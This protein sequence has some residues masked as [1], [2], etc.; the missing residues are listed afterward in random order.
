M[1]TLRLRS[2]L[3]SIANYIH[4]LWQVE[5]MWHTLDP[6]LHP[7]LPMLHQEHMRKG[8]H[9]WSWYL[10]QLTHKKGHAVY[11]RIKSFAFFPVSCIP[12]LP[13]GCAVL[14]VSC[15]VF[16]NNTMFSYIDLQ[17]KWPADFWSSYS[18]FQ[19]WERVRITFWIVMELRFQ[20]TDHRRTWKCNKV[21]WKK[22]LL[23]D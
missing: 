4:T 15:Y 13:W 3:G 19:Y 17:M 6:C 23:A 18:V 8:M 20:G 7:L 11:N 16:I 12:H 2:M 5:R 14:A 1:Q 9:R 10:H 21:I 22:I